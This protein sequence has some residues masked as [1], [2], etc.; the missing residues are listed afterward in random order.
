M[1]KTAEELIKK[2]AG[3]EDEH[4]RFRNMYEDVYRYG[5]PGRYNTITE[6]DTN[7]Q[8]N[9]EVIYSSVFEQ[10]CDEFVQRFQSLVCPVNTNWIDFEAG[11]MFQ[12][13]EGKIGEQR[14]L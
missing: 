4:S 2:Q 9:R 14:T 11:Y 10:A 3:C 1:K 13:D 6:T 7:G 12:N 5:M 8:K